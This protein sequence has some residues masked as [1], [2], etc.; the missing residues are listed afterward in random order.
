MR[1]L[2]NITSQPAAAM[3]SADKIS[4]VISGIDR[5]LSKQELK[6]GINVLSDQALVSYLRAA[7]KNVKLGSFQYKIQ[8]IQSRLLRGETLPEVLEAFELSPASFNGAYLPKLSIPVQKVDKEYLVKLRRSLKKVG[9]PEIDR[10]VRW[11]WP[12]NKIAET[13]DLHKQ[14]VDA[15]IGG[16]GQREYH[17]IQR[18]KYD[19][20]LKKEASLEQKTYMPVRQGLIEVLSKVI[21]RS[22][23]SIDERTNEGW[24]QKRALEY[25][26]GLKRHKHAIA[27]DKT[28]EVFRRYKEARDNGK[29]RTLADL[30]DGL[31]LWTT[32][33][34][35]LL[36]YFDLPYLS[37]ELSQKDKII[38]KKRF[39]VAKGLKFNKTDAAYFLGVSERILPS[40][41]KEIKPILLP[42]LVFSGGSTWLPY[43]VASQVY[44]A[45]DSGFSRDEIIFLLDKSSEIIDHALKN[46]PQIEN[47]II[48][49]LRKLYP[50]RDV[51]RPYN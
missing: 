22:L 3:S 38:A 40:P 13:L 35:R 41:V 47:D 26:I 17:T 18:R 49:N 7:R 9:N 37:Y 33:V 10:L 21:S 44:Q 12:Q 16:S 6:K 34:R 19:S 1:T 23:S 32:T 30:G 28:L 42:K 50:E 31:N 14:E 51:K 8:S 48:V 5:G 2:E 27:F 15:Y 11:G 39:K 45:Q 4:F 20:R 36:Q 24:A 25:K 29:V 46:R 43:R